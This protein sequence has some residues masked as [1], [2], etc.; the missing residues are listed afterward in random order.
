MLLGEVIAK[1]WANY[2]NLPGTTLT[3]P[4]HVTSVP[5]AIIMNWILDKLG[6]GKINWDPATLKREIQA[7]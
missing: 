7:S 3:A 1:R 4:H 5:Y 2:Y 6:A